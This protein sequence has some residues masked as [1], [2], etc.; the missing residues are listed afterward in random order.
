[1]TRGDEH[2]PH[3]HPLIILSND[4]A[5]ADANRASINVLFGSTRRPAIGIRPFEIQCD[6]ADGFEKSTV[7]D[8]SRIYFISKAKLGRA[9][10]SVSRVRRVQTSRKI[11]EVFR[12]MFQ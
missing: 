3:G 7:I 11:A 4:E 8:C 5:C 1:M 6:E 10:G 2:D 12:F 9:L